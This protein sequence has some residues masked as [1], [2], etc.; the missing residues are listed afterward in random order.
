VLVEV[1]QPG[2]AS[3]RGPLVV[4]LVAEDLIGAGRVAQSVPRQ[5]TP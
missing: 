1:G 2:G 4:D 3:K 5:A